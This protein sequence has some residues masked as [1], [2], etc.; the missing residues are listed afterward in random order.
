[1][2][3]FYIYDKRQL[4]HRRINLVKSAG[5]I[6]TAVVV[7]SALSYYAGRKDS[8]KGLTEYEK[9]VILNESDEFSKEKF[10]GMLKELNVKFPYIVMAQSIIE[11]GHWKSNIFRENNNLFGMKE[12]KQRITTAGGTQNNHAFYAHWRSSVY[13]YAFYQSSYLKTINTEEEYFQYLGASYAEAADYVAVV[14][15]TV[16]R[17]GLKELFN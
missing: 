8:V 5:V 16:E 4:I 6:L 17:E 13:D 10:A 11:T 14:K 3:M 7:V 9:V 12:A 2:P 15:A 1:M